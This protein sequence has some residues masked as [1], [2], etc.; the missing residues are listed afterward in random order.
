MQRPP[1][2][3]FVCAA[4][5]GYTVQP[6]TGAAA[7][8]TQQTSVLAQ[9]TSNPSSTYPTSTYPVYAAPP[10]T[11]AAQQQH[12]AP[13][14]RHLCRAPST[15]LGSAVTLYSVSAAHTPYSG[16][17]AQYSSGASGGSGAPYT[18]GGVIGYA[19][20]A[21]SS[22][23]SSPLE[24]F[25]AGGSGSRRSS[26]DSRRGSG[27]GSGMRILRRARTLRRATRHRRGNGCTVE[28]KAGSPAQRQHATPTPA[29]VNSS[30]TGTAAQYAPGSTTTYT[31]SPT[32]QYA[33]TPQYTTLGA[34]PCTLTARRRARDGGGGAADL[35]FYT[36]ASSPVSSASTSSSSATSE[37]C[38]TSE[39]STSE[40]E[41]GEFDAPASTERTTEFA[42][43]HT[44]A[45]DF[46][47]PRAHRPIACLSSPASAASDDGC[48]ESDDG[49]AEMVY[50]P[51]SSKV[52]VVHLPRFADLERWSPGVGEVVPSHAP[53]VPSHAPQGLAHTHVPSHTLP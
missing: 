33:T 17:P 50:V 6:S 26:G 19:N 30:A 24:R 48:D 42:T 43:R 41:E 38:S 16:G 47:Q 51:G 15:S 53:Q 35:Y 44:A 12:H 37:S 29:P 4:P 10:T 52:R 31:S 45:S 23:T 18:T 13:R 7:Y 11:T 14:T 36:L 28:S 27:A 2:L 25:G 49:D 5:S 40:D 9:A 1:L 3:V 20:G 39:E 21:G 8:T 34:T 22:S 32:A 46:A